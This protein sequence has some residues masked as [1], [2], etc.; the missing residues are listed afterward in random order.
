MSQ[1]LTCPAC[2]LPVGEHQP[3]ALQT[4]AGGTGAWQVFHASCAPEAP[5]AKAA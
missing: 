4:A 5:S 3:K 1:L 2:R